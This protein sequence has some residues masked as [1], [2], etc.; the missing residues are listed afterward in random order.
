MQTSI[1]TGAAAA[2]PVAGSSQRAARVSLSAAALFLV[3]LSFLHVIKPELDPSWHFISEYAIGDHGWI[4]VV[5]FLS[6]A[7]SCAALFVSIRRDVRTSGGKVGLGFL[8]AG[9]TGL[10]IAAVFT[11]DP[12]TASEN[13]A[14][15]HGTL[16]GVGNVIGTLAIPIAAVLLTRSLRRNPGWSPA[17]RPLLWA[18]GIA[19]TGFLVFELS[20]AVMVPGHELGPDVRIG[21]PN[22]FLIVSYSVWL[23]VVA[24]LATRYGGVRTRPLDGL[25]K[26]R[27]KQ[28]LSADGT[29]ITF[30]QAGEGPP[31]VLVGGALSFRRF[32]WSRKLAE[33]L[34]NDFTVINYDRRGRGG[35]GD[36]KPYAVHREIE[37]IAALID[38][39]GGSAAVFGLSSGGA[40][41]LEAAAHGLPMTNLAVYEP[42]FMV[43]QPENRPPVDY[44][45]QLTR[46]LSEDRRSDAVALFMKVVG[47][48]RFAIQIMRLFPFWKQFKAVAHTLPYDAAVM[49]D[50][51]LPAERLDSVRVRTLAICGEKSP[52]V[53]RDAAQ[54]VADAVPGAQRRSLQRQSHGVKPAALAPTLREFFA[55][56]AGGRSASD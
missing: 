19:L 31:V 35:S 25:R 33:L 48:P 43:G 36:T 2:R 41:A 26:V 7:L 45:A 1:S 49:G 13:G 51:S 11:S 15:T 4:M 20:F 24:G 50:F 34:A 5:A 21:W 18:A 29:A 27:V 16:H 56:D 17:R 42:P 52:E 55:G 28:V 47:V 3:L 23:L 8:L 40:L 12:I 22:R 32:S 10:F 46:L 44:E 39:A 54:A 6:L 38:E 14:T 37:D 53:L 30:D 9:A